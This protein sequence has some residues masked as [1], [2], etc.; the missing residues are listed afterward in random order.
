MNLPDPKMPWPVLPYPT[1]VR[2]S[3]KADEC[4]RD[5]T[6]ISHT[7]KTKEYGGRNLIGEPELCTI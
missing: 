5:V 1:R 4:R 6:R 3:G 7:Q 2:N